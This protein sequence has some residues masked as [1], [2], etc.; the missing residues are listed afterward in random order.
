MK[1]Q[2][3]VIPHDVILAICFGNSGVIRQRWDVTKGR[4][5]RLL[6]STGHKA[7]QVITACGTTRIQLGTEN[8]ENCNMPWKT[9]SAQSMIVGIW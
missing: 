6:S 8:M 2:D 7:K 5:R 9:I 3:P 4:V 1:P